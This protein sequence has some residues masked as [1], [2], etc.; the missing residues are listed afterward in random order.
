MSLIMFPQ[1]A[2]ALQNYNVKSD[3]LLYYC[4]ILTLKDKREW[5][6][7]SWYM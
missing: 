4:E 1:S 2:H 7:Y 5:N 6:F 3:M